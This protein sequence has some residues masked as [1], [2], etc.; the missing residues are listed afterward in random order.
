METV[1]QEHHNEGR[2]ARVVEKKLIGRRV[3]LSDPILPQAC[4]EV[5]LHNTAEGVVSAHAAAARRPVI[6]RLESMQGSCKQYAG[7]AVHALHASA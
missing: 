3:F 4:L 2:V 6:R 7:Q 1:T 5:M